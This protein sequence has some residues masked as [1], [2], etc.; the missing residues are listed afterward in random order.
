MAFSTPIL[1]IV[2]NRPD[3]TRV[4]LE[5]IKEVQPSHLFIASDGPR[6]SKPGEA[7]VVKAVRQMV[8]DAV[9]WPCEVKTLF[10]DNNVGCKM[11]VSG[12]VNWFFENVEEGIILE[13]DCVPDVSFFE[14]CQTLL[15]K[16]RADERVM[17][18]GGTNF[19]NGKKRG[20]GSYYFSKYN[21]IWG[22]ATWRRAWHK[23][24]ST[25][26]GYREFKEKDLPMLLPNNALRKSWLKK[27]DLV[28]T[29]KLDTWDY[30]WTYSIWKERGLCVVPNV[31][32]IS[33]IGFGEG[34]THTKSKNVVSAMAT[35][36]IV[37]LVHPP[38][39]AIDV[40]ADAYYEKSFLLTRRL[41]NKFKAYLI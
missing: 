8:V 6:S 3:T 41:I 16:Y 2:F 19:Q 5:R 15:N 36:T 21:Y 24:D 17:H 20:S 9:T 30:Q 14:Y 37:P 22:W 31:N 38:M 12:A 11:G 39:V 34:A 1:F 18:I 40:A 33:N 4:V 25:M 10:R 35:S 13:D 7:E 28:F 23:Y 29:N 32:L 26:S 27:F